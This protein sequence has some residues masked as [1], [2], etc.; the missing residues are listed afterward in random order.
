MK[1]KLLGC[2]VITAF[3]I[4]GCS[5]T[6]VSS[7]VNLVTSNHKIEN[8]DFDVM[9]SLRGDGTQA[10]AKAVFIDMRTL[11]E[12]K[13]GTI[14]SS[15]SIDEI[16]SNKERF[17]KTP[18]D[19]LFVLFGENANNISIPDIE[20]T[21]ALL[22]S[23]GFNNIKTYLAGLEEWKEK[24]YTEIDVLIAKKA[25]EENS[26]VFIDARPRSKFLE[27]TI[28]GSISIPDTEVKKL[29]GRFP[30]DKNIDV[31]LFCSGLDCHKS[32]AVADVMLEQDY[33]NI[34]VF[35]GGVPAWKKEKLPTTAQR[36]E[37]V[38]KKM[39]EPTVVKFIDDVMLGQDEGTVDGE[40]LKE[41][42]ETNK[43]PT[44][45]VIVDLRN[46]FTYE[47]GHIMGAINIDPANIVLDNLP[48]DKIAILYCATGTTAMETRM[49]LE[50]AK[51]DVSKVLYFDANIKCESDNSCT[52]NVNEPLD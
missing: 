26:A 12:Y 36:A 46:K 5:S 1:Y 11:D 37:V 28:P 22:K 4:G 10:G 6:K 7:E 3:L 15:L 44:N 8:I 27:G 49:N 50:K 34:Y 42:I 13:A 25:F 33:E 39:D 51:Y 19:K 45:I 17:S 32:N 47:N 41:L 43:I 40:W 24:R 2:I 9:D 16:T 20:K 23:Q 31:I 30:K 52:I 21:V 38:V 18:K 29:D 48:K 35:I 14:S